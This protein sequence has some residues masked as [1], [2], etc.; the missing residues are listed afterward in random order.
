MAFDGQHSRGW[1]AFYVITWLLFGLFLG[2]MIWLAV[3]IGEVNPF[4]CS[5]PQTATIDDYVVFFNQAAEP[6]S[7]PPSSVTTGVSNSTTCQIFHS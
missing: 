6:L 4:L 1:I 2:L 5:W 7:G 3:E